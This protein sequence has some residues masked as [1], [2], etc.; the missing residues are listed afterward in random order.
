MRK[1]LILTGRYLPGHKDGGP[2]RTM[3]NVTDALGDDYEFYI[4][5]LDRDHGDTEP[6]P[7]IKYGE[8]NRVG[9]A[10]VR[11]VKPNGFTGDLIREL[12]KDAD[13]IYTCGFYDDY[14]YKTL[15]LNKSGKL[16]GK[17]VVVASMGSF[18]KGA[19]AHKAI[20]KKVFISL[21]KVLGAFKN[22]VW[23]VTSELE[24]KDLK[25]V[26]GENAKYIVAEDLPRTN[27][28]GR[29]FPL[30]ES[31]VLKVAFLS[32]IVPHKG[33]MTAI[34]ALR[35]INRQTE[36]NIYGPIGDNAYWDSCKEEIDKLPKN[37]TANYY[38][39]VPSEKVQQKLQENDLFLFPTRSENYGHVVFE[40]L[41]VGCVP[42][43]SDQT[44][45]S[46]L[47]EINA[48]FIVGVEDT[49]GYGAAI[50][51]FAD[52]SV[53][54]KTV[55]AKNGVAVAKEKVEISKKNTGYN[56]I[57]NLTEV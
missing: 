44:P 30:K 28:P 19:L 46:F 36:F 18:S 1:I 11:Y 41:S 34:R 17:P 40:A 55:M 54:E 43:I 57:F 21:L 7:D 38:G 49:E 32:R 22:I 48:G 3:I 13:L 6:Y 16:N 5:A 39:D 50:D 52:M 42:I 29:E 27:V 8:W 33:L 51:R 24:A 14:G 26:I 23:S 10:N 15:L 31:E 37:I 9:K 56:V 2:L 35:G 20:K 4:V 45:W 12:S 25:R 47:Q 53:N